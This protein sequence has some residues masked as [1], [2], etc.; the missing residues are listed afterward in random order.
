MLERLAEQE[1]IDQLTM[2]RKR[3]KVQEHKK[4]IEKLWQIKLNQYRE[5]KEA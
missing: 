1:R 3:Q 5:A 4:E 2:E